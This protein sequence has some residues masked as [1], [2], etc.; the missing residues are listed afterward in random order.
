M[1][2]TNCS[3]AVR[4]LESGGQPQR[5]QR[6]VSERNSQRQEPDCLVLLRG[7]SSVSEKPISGSSRSADRAGSSHASH[8]HPAI[9]SWQS[10]ARPSRTPPRS[11][12]CGCCPIAAASA[13]PPMPRDCVPTPLTMPSITA[14]IRAACHSTEREPVHH[15]IH[16]R[17]IVDLVDEILVVDQR[18]EPAQPRGESLPEPSD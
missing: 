12:N 3:R 5:K 18:V 10:A 6:K 8:L 7:M 14:L 16:H 1:S 17:R 11:H 2:V 4:D 9:D 15:R 13:Q